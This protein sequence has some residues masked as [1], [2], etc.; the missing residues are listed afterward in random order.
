MKGVEEH[1]VL[2]YNNV[3]VEKRVRYNGSTVKG[4]RFREYVRQ[5]REDGRCLMG[6]E[7]PS[8]SIDKW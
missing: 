4:S 1:L 3:G 5:V 2:G 8:I 7:G 6:L